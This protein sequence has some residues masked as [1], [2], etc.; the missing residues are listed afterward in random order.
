MVRDLNERGKRLELEQ[1][2]QEP[3]DRGYSHRLV[4]IGHASLRCE[5]GDAR[6]A[7]IEKAEL[8]E[9]PVVDAVGKSCTNLIPGRPAACEVIFHHPLPERFADDGPEVVD[10]GAFA[11]PLPIRLRGHWSDAIHHRIG[12]G[13]VLMDPVAQQRVDS[14]RRGQ[15]RATGG[16][17]VGRQVVAAEDSEWTH[18]TVAAHCQ[19]SCYAIKRRR[20]AGD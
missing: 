7:R 15:R 17:A 3:N 12:K 13:A 20:A 19:R 6:M 11:Q 1:P 2:L 9:L 4:D 10:A 14:L 16:I 5:V 18:P 8:V